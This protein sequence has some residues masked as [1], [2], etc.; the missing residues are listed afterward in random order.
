MGKAK[1]MGHKKDA[2]IKC[3]KIDC[4]WRTFWA[5]HPEDGECSLDK[6]IIEDVD[7]DP[8][9]MSYHIDDDS[10]DVKGLHPVDGYEVISDTGKGVSF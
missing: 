3:N 5:S 7:G 6:I 1:Y 8:V 4:H 2:P 9:C 10:F